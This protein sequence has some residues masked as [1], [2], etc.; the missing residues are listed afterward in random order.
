MFV[1]SGA[2]AS[3][4]VSE[5]WQ[6]KTRESVGL[7]KRGEYKA[8]LKLSERVIRDMA[9]RLGPGDSEKQSFGIA[10]THKALA[11]AGLGQEDEALWYW[12]IAL[13]LYPGLA[14]ADLAPYGKPGEF[15]RSHADLRKPAEIPRLP[16]PVTPNITVPVVK[17]RV[18][19]KYPIGAQ[20]FAVSGITIVEVLVSRDGKLSSPVVLKELPAPTITYA[21]L[22]A[23]RRWTFEPATIDGQPTDIIFNVTFNYKLR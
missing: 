10:L 12:H 11:L 9:D 4:P 17:K 20:A 13:N 3:D 22:E 16:Y 18:D 7:L 8:S 1:A 2:I 19:P 21:A 23:L 6:K 5:S 14:K 15:L